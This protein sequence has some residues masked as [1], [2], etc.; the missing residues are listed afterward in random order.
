MPVQRATIPTFASYI[1][2]DGPIL[3]SYLRKAQMK[4]KGHLVGR[5]F[6]LLVQREMRCVVKYSAEGVPTFFLCVS[7]FM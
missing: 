3:S 1:R 6:V 5:C 2:N 7:L 4:G